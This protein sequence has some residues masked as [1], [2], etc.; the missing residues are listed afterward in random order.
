MQA[1][2]P[3]VHP[4]RPRL[5]A[6]AGSGTRRVLSPGDSNTY[7]LHLDRSQ[8][9]PMQ[10]ARLWNGRR[11]TE[12]AA[13]HG[14]PASIGSLLWRASRVYRLA[15]MAW[16][17]RESSEV[18]VVADARASKVIY[19]VADELIRQ[20]GADAGV[21]VVDLASHFASRCDRP[22]CPRLF[23][24]DDHATAE[25]NALAAEVLAATE[26]WGD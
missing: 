26:R 5:S 1:A 20:A 7:G 17:A 21:P 25:G 24:E 15:C 16:H 9:Y 18:E 10:L 2:A 12:P 4:T 14:E 8:A 23:F 6:S 22:P 13:L 19:R 3:W 11:W